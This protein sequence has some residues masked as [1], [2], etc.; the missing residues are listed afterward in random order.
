MNG[1][2]MDDHIALF[3]QT[4]VENKSFVQIF[5]QQQADFYRPAGHFILRVILQFAQHN[6][7]GY[8]V[9]NL[10]LFFLIVFLFFRLFEKITGDKPLAFLAAVLYGVHPINGMNVNYIT[11]SALAT[12]ILCTQ[13]SFLYFMRFSD[14]RRKRDYFLS[15]VFFILALLSHEISVAIPVY[16]AAY[17]FFIKKERWT[18]SLGLLAPFVVFMALY[19]GARFKEF[20]FARLIHGA[21]EAMGDP[22]GHFTTWYDLVSWFVSKLVIP[23]E[24]IFL[25]SQK[26]GAAYFPGKAIVFALILAATIYL[27]FFRW[28]QGWKPFV[29][30][31]FMVG[32]LPSVIS[33]FSYFPI[34][35]PLLEPHWFYF[36]QMGFFLFLAAFLM[37][38]IRRHGQI[39][40][41]LCV[42]L[43][44][45]LVA[46][47]WDYN[48][49]WQTQEKYARYW[50]SLN[51]GNLTPYY[52]L[53]RSLMDQGDCVGA[54]KAFQD[55]IS[56][57]NTNTVYL[58]ADKGH[59]LD[60]V[61]EDN[62]SAFFLNSA[63]A[64]DPGYAKTYY[65]VGLYLIKR[66]DRVNALR[67]FQ[68]AVELDPKF[69]PAW[70]YLKR[71][72]Q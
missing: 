33:A 37:R 2:M 20:F 57:L 7:L 64:E 45:I 23:H 66:G 24:I 42:V 30:T 53:G 72:E 55:G 68:K 12:F 69:S 67:E 50:L 26:Y 40:I 25:W 21:S 27:I 58:L 1:F 49:K 63:M 39:G 38:L 65:Y 61:G 51:R 54:L 34:V 11:A 71:L 56:T 18:H 13:A 4:G 62:R 35:W 28:K 41:F 8:H 22:A 31:V 52:G 5:S 9:A 60:V 48:S 70:E 32:L 36:S 29:L 14:E 3:G 17:L 47:A 43:V 16:L 10:F 59:C 19:F 44:G 6:P 15:F 46:L